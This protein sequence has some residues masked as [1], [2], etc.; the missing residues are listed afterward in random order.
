[1]VL[2]IV[3]LVVFSVLGIFSVRYRILAKEAFEC[4]FRM[5]TLRPCRTKFDDKIK[6]KIV[7]KLIGK[8]SKLAG[9]VYKHFKP[10]SWAFT[11]TFF[12][13]TAYSALVVYNL[14]VFGTCQPGAA[15]CVLTQDP[16]G[17]LIATLTCYEAQIAYFVILLAIVAVLL[18][19]NKKIIFV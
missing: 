9:F 2:C 6:S 18:I 4:V 12:V 3:A 7:A 1:M 16:A 17:K 10:L 8:S 5:V 19:K 13:S 15:S 14:V 11:T